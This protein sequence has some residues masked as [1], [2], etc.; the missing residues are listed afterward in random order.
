MGYLVQSP[1]PPWLALQTR[2]YLWLPCFVVVQ[3][4]SD[5]TSTIFDVCRSRCCLCLGQHR[6]VLFRGVPQHLLED[7]LIKQGFSKYVR[8]TLELISDFLF[9]SYLCS[10]DRNVLQKADDVIHPKLVL[11]SMKLGSLAKQSAK[12]KG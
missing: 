6:G 4:V 5:N 10:L 3:A 12:H 1:G 11:M 8:F 2:V 7:M 9:T